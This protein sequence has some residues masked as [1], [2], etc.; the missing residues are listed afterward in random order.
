MRSQNSGRRT[1]PTALIIRTA[2]SCNGE[3]RHEFESAPRRCPFIF[4]GFCYS[5]SHHHAPCCAPY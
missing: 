3:D 5:S 2:G 1:L 4:I